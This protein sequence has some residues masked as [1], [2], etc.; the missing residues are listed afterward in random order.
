ME[1]SITF[2]RG[3]IRAEITADAD[4]DFTA[5]LEQLAAFAEAYD[6]EGDGVGGQVAVETPETGQDEADEPESG[7]DG[8]EVADAETDRSTVGDDGNGGAAAEP[9]EETDSQ[10]G[11]P[12]LDVDDASPLLTETALSEAELARLVA[13]G[14]VTDGAEVVEPPAVNADIERVSDGANAALV[15]EAAVVLTVLDDV[16]GV[17]VLSQ[18]TLIDAL[19]DSELTPEKW[20]DLMIEHPDAEIF[21]NLNIRGPDS[22]ATVEVREAAK[23]KAYELREIVAGQ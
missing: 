10:D 9:A 17:R 21:F 18:S 6:G 11:T 22:S 7:E 5:V 4:E 2:E 23:E 20:D 19:S 3:P 14:E 8:E 16:H 1:V 12:T 15:N 13:T